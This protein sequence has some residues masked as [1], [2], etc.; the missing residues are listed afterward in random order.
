MSEWPWGMA[1]QRFLCATKFGAV[2]IGPE[3]PEL[4]RAQSALLKGPHI[5]LFGG[6]KHHCLVPE[7]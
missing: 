3:V 7:R 1:S 5:S 4:T 6:F 2:R